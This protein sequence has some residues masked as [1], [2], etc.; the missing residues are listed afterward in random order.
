MLV[1]TALAVLGAVLVVGCAHAP[2]TVSQNASWTLTV[3]YTVDDPDDADAI[4]D[5]AVVG[6]ACQVD[7]VVTFDQIRTVYIV[8][9][10]EDVQDTIAKGLSRA[11][12][13]DKREVPL[14][15][16]NLQ[17]AA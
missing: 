4:I 1:R 7:R 11:L 15:A 17:D 10:T 16:L 2:T 6:H 12:L 14:M 8:H 9:A 13:I 5:S 3:A